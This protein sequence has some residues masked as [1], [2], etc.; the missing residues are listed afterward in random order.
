MRKL[1]LILNRSNVQHKFP[2]CCLF[3]YF[4]FLRCCNCMCV[5]TFSSY[6]KIFV[7]RLMHLFCSD[8]FF[9]FN[10]DQSGED[11]C[12]RYVCNDTTQIVSLR[13]INL[14]LTQFVIIEECLEQ[15]IWYCSMLM[16]YLYGSEGSPFPSISIVKVFRAKFCCSHQVTLC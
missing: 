2:V 16:K 1:F 3:F 12:S 11:N 9:L 10:F 4:V 8:F 6:D 5:R 14:P 13:K 7:L 15:S